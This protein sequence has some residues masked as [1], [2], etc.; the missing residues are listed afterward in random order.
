MLDRLIGDERHLHEEES[1]GH[2]IR[3]FPYGRVLGADILVTLAIVG[4]TIALIV[5]GLILMNLFALVG[6][7]LTSEDLGV[8]AAMR[9]SARLVRRHFWLTFCLATVPLMVEEAIE[10]WVGRGRAGCADRG[11]G[12]RPRALRDAR[13]IGCRSGR[14]ATRRPTRGSLSP[15][16]GRA[17]TRPSAHDP[18]RARDI[19]HAAF[20]TYRREPVRIAASA[21]VVFGLLGIAE[22]RVDRSFGDPGSEALALVVGLAAVFSTAGLVFYPALLDRI[23]DEEGVV[24]PRRR[25]MGQILRRL[26]YVRL[27]LADLLFVVVVTVG[28]LLCVVP[29]LAFMNL[30]AIAGPLITTENLGVRAAFRRSARLVRSHFW[31]TLGV[32]T[33]PVFVEGALE[34]S[35]SGATHGGPVVL[36]VAVHA[37]FGALIA[38]VVGLFEVHLATRLAERDPIVP[39]RPVSSGPTSAI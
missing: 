27:L 29:G 16:G 25:S 2:I 35:V 1:I 15:V 34:E 28:L 14:G 4:G 7:L 37:V 12:H 31:L 26:P 32:V 36:A 11:I 23:V 6:P 21:I 9:R 5:P 30:F 10:E 39:A 18:I 22:A 38:S 13:G 8:R 24:G 3:T 17:V 19:V 33:L 20:T